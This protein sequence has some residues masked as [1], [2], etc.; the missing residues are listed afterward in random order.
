[1]FREVIEMEFGTKG[2]KI[3]YGGI[4]LEEQDSIAD[5]KGDIYYRNKTVVKGGQ[6]G[7]E[8]SK[9]PIGTSQEVLRV[10]STGVIEWAKPEKEISL[11]P[12]S[13]ATAVSVVD[14]VEGYVV[15]ASM[16]GM[17]LVAG[18]CSVYDKGITGTTTIIIRRVRVE[19]AIGDAS[20]QFDISDQGSNTFRYTW[21]GTGT[22]PVIADSLASL[23]IGDQIDVQGQNFNANNNGLQVITGVGTNY[24][25]VT[26][27]SGVAE[28]NVTI[29][30]GS[31]VPIKHRDM[32]STGITIADEFY[33]ADGVV[34]TSYDDLQTGDTLYRDVTTIHSGTAPNGL[35]DTWTFRD[36]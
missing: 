22:D 8:M 10:S 31:I 2:L 35:A 12:I 3:D 6:V 33:A 36:P 11:Q 27:A 24:F 23:Q 17:N 26:N 4:M 21:D 1:M 20:S 16:T 7:P 14:G 29:G 18:I 32:L 34:N 13:T 9:L 15:P 19:P 25:E 28:N 5:T 30:T